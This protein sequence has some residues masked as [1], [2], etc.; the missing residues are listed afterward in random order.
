MFS[1]IKLMLANGSDIEVLDKVVKMNEI[2]ETEKSTNLNNE[3]TT[4]SGTLDEASKSPDLNVTKESL[5]STNPDSSKESSNST[6]I[7]TPKP[8]QLPLNSD[9]IEGSGIDDIVAAEGF[10][11]ESRKP[12]MHLKNNEEDDESL[13]HELIMVET[14]RKPK[15]KMEH[16]EY[17]VVV[18]GSG[19]EAN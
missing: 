19:R 4:I 6:E 3:T 9:S 10:L 13:F 17:K 8:T 7:S 15:S 2:E 11:V 14:R 16:I 1:N 18:D 5:N 12:L